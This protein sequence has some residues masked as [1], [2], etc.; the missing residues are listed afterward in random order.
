V[1]LAKEV[2]VSW[3]KDE[4]SRL[5]VRNHEQLIIMNLRTG[6]LRDRSMFFPAEVRSNDDEWGRLLKNAGHFSE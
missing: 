4:Y 2:T 3:V 1:L 6:F 5:V